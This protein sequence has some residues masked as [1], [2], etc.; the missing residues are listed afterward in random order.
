MVRGSLIFVFTGAVLAG[1]TALGQCPG[2]G[3][4]AGGM[5]GT[6]TAAASG[7]VDT[8]PLRVLTGPGSLAFDQMMAQRI[9]QQRYM[10]AMQ[11]QHARDERLAARREQAAKKRAEVV[12]S[13]ARNRAS[14][15]PSGQAAAPAN[16]R[17]LLAYQAGRR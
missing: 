14:A 1:T 11:Q 2:G 5:I 15:A 3:Q 4:A 8:T 13:R 12:A 16:A 6:S 9:A 10:L 7:I 17:S